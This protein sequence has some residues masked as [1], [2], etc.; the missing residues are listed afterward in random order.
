MK[1][2]KNKLKQIIKEEFSATMD[3]VHGVEEDPVQEPEGSTMELLDQLDEL[4]RKIKDSLS[5]ASE[6]AELA[7][8][9][10]VGAKKFQRMG[11]TSGPGREDA[12][13]E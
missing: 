4:V 6:E 3:E 12:P 11:A 2:T 8:P 9:R 13:F 7:E 5:G 10:A 1:L